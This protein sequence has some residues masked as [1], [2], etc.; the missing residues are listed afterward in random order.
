MLAGIGVN[1]LNSFRDAPENLRD[2]LVSLTDLLPDWPLREACPEVCRETFPVVCS[3]AT[4]CGEK[5]GSS[6]MES[7]LE[8]LLGELDVQLARLARNPEE[9]VRETDARCSQK[10]AFVALQTPAGP[11]SGFCSGL[12]PNG[13]L[14]IDG[15][16]FYSGT[17]H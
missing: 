10:G 3:G 17:I 16:P 8:E 14:M 1:L 13:A 2:V 15:K 12:A 4:V 7:F 5:R 6:A 11:V 9:I